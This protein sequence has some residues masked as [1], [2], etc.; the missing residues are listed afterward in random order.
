MR[1]HRT[2]A[3]A[4]VLFLCAL[5]SISRAQEESN[6]AVQLDRCQSD[7]TACRYQ[8]NLD[9]LKSQRDSL[10]RDN[11]LLQQTTI[12]LNNA[13]YTTSGVKRAQEV[14]DSCKND[15]H[16]TVTY[17][18]GRVKYVVTNLV[19]G[20]LT[21]SYH[22]PQIE[23]NNPAKLT[24]EFE[25]RSVAT[26]GTTNDIR[27][28]MRATYDPSHLKAGYLEQESGNTQE[29]NLTLNG[30]QKETWIW[31]VEPLAGFEKDQTDVLCDLRF[32]AAP[33]LRSTPSMPDTAPPWTGIW[34]QTAQWT[35]APGWF[36]RFWSL[37]FITCVGGLTACIS[38]LVAYLQARSEIRKLK[39][40]KP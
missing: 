24:L 1:R 8:L 40:G 18:E 16:R 35:K 3:S 11:Q 33:A 7:L 19:I 38:F 32:E 34:R 20:T 9:P 17:Q 23:S 4:A 2:V 36:S 30:N 21:L 39:S 37:Y 27:W 6:P 10:T 14:L 22:P 13:I 28:Y 15:P 26:F 12:N 29:R 25:P 5:A 31:Q